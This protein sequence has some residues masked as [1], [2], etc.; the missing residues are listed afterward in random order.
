MSVDSQF[1][2]TRPFITGV[3]GFIGSSMADRLLL[4]GL[5]VVGYDNMSTGVPEFLSA[6]RS[7][8]AFRFV[9]GDVLNGDH[10]AAAMNGC[11]VVF[12]FAANADVRFGL[13]HPRRDLEQNTI[14]THTVLEAMR[15][16]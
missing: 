3:A 15:A 6:A 2:F 5:Q 1:R 16:N 13:E 7:N 8:P 11:D 9:E 12:H 14:G 10:L 4:Q